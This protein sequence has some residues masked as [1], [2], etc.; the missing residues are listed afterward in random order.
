MK[1]PVYLYT[2]RFEVI[3][4]LDNNNRIN[5]IMYQRDLKLQKGLKNTIQ[6]QFKNSDQKFVDISQK[7]FVFVLFDTINQRNLIEKDVEIIDDGA[8]LLL[9]GLGQVTFTESELMACESVDYKALIKVVDADGSYTP[10]YANT[11]Y[12]VGITVE[13]KHDVYPTL[14]PSQET[15]KFDMYYNADIDKRQ[16]EYYTG[17][18][19]AHPEFKSNVALHTI[20]TYMTNYKGRV[21]I[22]GTLENDPA[23]FGNYATINDTTYNGF[24]G[25]DY[26]NFNGVWAKVRVRYIPAKNPVSQENNDTDYAGTV[27]KVLYRC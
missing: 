14:Q 27:D 23:T 20:A 19:P 25:I 21:L 16:Y 1:L 10:A 22:E 8:T 26:K 7:Q 24:T 3:L 15:S 4:D 5:Q 2:N 13:V 11:Y 6:L 17:N 12:G 9:R 18:L